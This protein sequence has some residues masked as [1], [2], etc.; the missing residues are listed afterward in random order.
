MNSIEIDSLSYDELIAL[1]KRI[2]ERLKYMDHVRNLMRVMDYQVGDDVTFE[3]SDGVAISGIVAKLNRKTVSVVTKEGERWN[4]SPQ[5]LSKPARPVLDT[6]QI[7]N[8]VRIDK[9]KEG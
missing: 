7:D 9:P 2:V 5:L 6:E 1:N 8:I 3:R 4:V